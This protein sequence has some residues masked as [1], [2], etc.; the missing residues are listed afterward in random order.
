M[1]LFQHHLPF[2]FYTQLLSLS[3][4]LFYTKPCMLILVSDLPIYW[5][6]KVKHTRE[7]ILVHCRASVKYNH[8]HSHLKDIFSCFHHFVI[9][10]SGVTRTFLVRAG[11]P[12][13][14]QV[15]EFYGFQSLLAALHRFWTSPR[16]HISD[17]QKFLPFYVVWYY[18]SLS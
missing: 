4:N 18:I 14:F 11:T 3:E 15:A 6:V 10:V 12:L 9:I 1:Q 16:K 8:T 17:T 13:T 2:N 5:W 7:W